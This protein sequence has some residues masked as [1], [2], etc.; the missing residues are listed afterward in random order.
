MMRRLLTLLSCLLIGLGALQAQ[1]ITA[2]GVVVDDSGMEVIGATVVLKGTKTGTVTGIDGDFTLK[3][4]QN[5]TLVFSMV[6]LKPVEQKAKANMKVVMAIDQQ[7]LD[8]VV[9]TG[10]GAVKKS[11]FTGSASVISTSSLEDIPSIG[12]DAKLAGAAA[13]VTLTTAS[14]QP[15]GVESL[16]IRGAGSIMASNEPLYVIDG[17]PMNSENLSG[18]DYAQSG[19]SSLSTINMNDVETITIIKDAGAAAMYGSR[20]ANGVVVITTKSGKVGK[21][22]VNVR[23]NWG[24][25]NMAIDYRPT[26]SGDDRRELLYYGLETSQLREVDKEGVPLYTA[27]QAKE[28]ADKNIDTYAEKPWSGWA[29][30]K[31]LLYR[32][33]SQANYEASI[34]SGSETFNAFSSLAYSKIDGL[35]DQSSFERFTGRIN[36]S[37][38]GVRNLRVD[39]NSTF[40]RTTQDSYI[41]GTG[42]AS[43]IMAVSWTASP[44]DYP[45]NKD[46]SWNTSNKFLL[47]NRGEANPLKEIAVNSARNKISRFLGSVAAKYDI[48]DGLYAKQTLSYDYMNSNETSWWDPQSNNGSTANGVLQVIGN[49]FMTLVS[50]THLGFTKS[51]GEVHNIDGLVGYEVEKYENKFNY[52][53]GQGFL[54]NKPVL[55]AATTT[56]A[57]GY[58]PRRRMLSYLAVFNYNYDNKYYGAVNYRRDG[59]S[60]FK[61]GKKWGDF[62]SVSGSWRITEEAFMASIKDQINDLR[63]RASYGVN[64]NLPKENYAYYASYRVRNNYFGEQGSGPARLAYEDLTWEKN[65]SLNIGFDMTFLDRFGVTFDWYTRNTTDLLVPMN[66]SETTGFSSIDINNGKMNNQGFELSLRSDNLTSS[67][68]KWSTTLNLAHNRNRLKQLDGTPR[69]QLGY[70][71]ELM[72]AVDN[73]FSMIYGFEYAGVDP[74]TG[75]ESFYINQGSD[76]RATTTDASKAEMVLLDKVDPTISGGLVNNLSY[77]GFDLAFTF[78]FSLGGH[79][80]DRASQR[81]LNKDGGINM[82]EGQVPKAYKLGDIWKQPGDNAKLPAFYYQNT[83]N[84]S[85]R[86]VHST[87]H[88]RLKNITLGYSL[89]KSLLRGSGVSNVRVFASAVNLLTFK[90]KDLVVDP[91]I[92]M[93][94]NDGIGRYGVVQFQTPPLRTVT[95]GVDLTF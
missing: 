10:Y 79:L 59:S 50:Q 21:T 80:Y 54:Y 1:D 17:I 42:Y 24:F 87:N 31:D 82:Y 18:F 76:P 92:P 27:Q 34:Q 35:T 3:V 62:W 16:R 36:T 69:I 4:P 89:P 95:F 81:F 49:E 2:S 71:D 37:F 40:S 67:E 43:P 14:G 83:N 73:P 33:G 29:D 7:L 11:S 22:T 32:N 48:Y 77:K 38:T 9:I 91:E 6:G 47:L 53:S 88:L 5:G 23:A 55:S 20:A 72:H 12:L 74:D 75:K 58:N 41:E 70:F 30:W 85:S 25:S 46:G 28:Y 51:L 19:T 94:P 66:I 45:Y 90:S 39:V 64:G 15:G 60:K 86:F 56:S 78:T 61:S 26:L 13:G 52:G 8:E 84:I 57:Q 93:D 68:V 44:Q 65:K 63:L